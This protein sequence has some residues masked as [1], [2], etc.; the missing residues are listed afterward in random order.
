MVV[1][2]VVRKGTA[3]GTGNELMRATTSKNEEKS[4]KE[5]IQ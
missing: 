3:R 4:D 5:S 2:V 1:V